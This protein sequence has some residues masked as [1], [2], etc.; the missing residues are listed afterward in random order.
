MPKFVIERELPGAGSLS[1]DELH[2]IAAKSNQV[3][4]NMAPRAQWLENFVT[5]DKRSTAST[6]LTERPLSAS[7]PRRAVSRPTWSAGCPS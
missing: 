5:G 3:L 1:S 6:S 4:T 2:S 7:T